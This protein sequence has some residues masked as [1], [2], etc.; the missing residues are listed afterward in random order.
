MLLADCQQGEGEGEGGSACILDGGLSGKLAPIGAC[1]HLTGRGREGGL[2][3]SSH[4]H[5]HTQFVGQTLM[6]CSRK[7]SGLSVSGP[8]LLVV[9]VVGGQTRRTRVG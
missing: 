9:V 5:T 7:S 3:R 8:L 1:L 4:T 2:L 6:K